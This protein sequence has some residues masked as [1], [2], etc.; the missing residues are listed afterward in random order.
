MN[1]TILT[2]NQKYLVIASLNLSHNYYLTNVIP[3]IEFHPSPKTLAFLKNYRLILKQEGSR[4][5]ILQEGKYE[6]SIWIPTIAIQEIHSLVFGI[7]F[8]DDMFQNKTNVPFYTSKDQK[9]FIPIKV[10]ENSNLEEELKIHPFNGGTFPNISDL[11][12]SVVKIKYETSSEIKNL[13]VGKIN[14]YEDFTTGIYTFHYENEEESTFIWSDFDKLY[15]GYVS[16]EIQQN[17]QNIFNFKFNNRSI[18]WQYI[19]VSNNLK[20]LESCIIV[21]EKLEMKFNFEENKKDQSKFVFTSINPVALKERYSN[22]L[23][24]EMMGEKLLNLPFPELKNFNINQID[25]KKSVNKYFLTTY[26]NL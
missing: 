4:L 24:L 19:L 14:S 3:N 21:D 2:L 10:G 7:K 13:S 6:G 8:N 22:K 9:F 5:I 26:V 16:I 1:K 17:A 23:S 12:T 15:D 18:H 25:V 20:D 11:K